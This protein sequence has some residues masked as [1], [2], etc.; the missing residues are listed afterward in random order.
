MKLFLGIMI[1]TLALLL[2]ITF[3]SAGMR[4]TPYGDFCPKCGKYGVCEELMTMEESRDAVNGYFR[5]QGINV[6]HV[7]GRGRFIQMELMKNNDTYDVILFDRK[8]GRMR[9]I[10]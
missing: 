4:G 3:V 6:R 9:S 10:Y 8:T 1:P 5:D 7:R 2:T